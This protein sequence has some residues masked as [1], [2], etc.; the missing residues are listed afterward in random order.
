M[1]LSMGQAALN[2]LR[3]DKDGAG[4]AGER[5]A[6]ILSS[7]STDTDGTLSPP[8]GTPADAG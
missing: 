5:A 7:Q 6:Q 2:A 1:V 3:S 4:Y 8:G